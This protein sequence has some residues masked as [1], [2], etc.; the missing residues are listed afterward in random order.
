[1]RIR[2]VRTD[3]VNL[4]RVNALY[5]RIETD[6]GLVGLGETDGNLPHRQGSPA[7]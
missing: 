6:T 4:G 2:N 3:L 1:M 7:H 5:V